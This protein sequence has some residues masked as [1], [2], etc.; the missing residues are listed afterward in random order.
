MI[1][2]G[3]RYCNQADCQ[4]VSTFTFKWPGHDTAGICDEHATWLRKLSAT[5]GHV[6]FLEPIT[7]VPSPT[8]A[9]LLEEG[10]R[11]WGP[12]VSPPEDD[13]ARRVVLATILVRLGVGVGD[14]CRHARGATK[15]GAVDVADVSKE[16]GNIIVSTIRWCGELGLDP[17]ECVRLA[18]EAQRKFAAENQER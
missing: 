11:I 12:S 6:V 9:Q 2:K 10:R 4:K 18:V 16:L 17:D 3:V 13:V 8:I 5:M 1:T 14:L 7:D 15:D